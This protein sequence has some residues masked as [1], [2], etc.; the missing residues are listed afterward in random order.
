M[1]E[2]KKIEN[3]GTSCKKDFTSRM[4]ENPWMLSTVVLI[5]LVVIFI[6][7]GLGP[8]GKVI[9]EN[10][11]GEIIVDLAKSQVGDIQIIEVSEKSGIY[12]IDYSSEQGTGV[13]YLTLDGK[14]LIGGLM[15]LEESE[16]DGV[17]EKESYT[18]EDKEKLLSFSE[19]LASKGIK[20]YGAGWCGYCKKLKETFG[21][22]ASPFY[23]ECQN[24]DGSPTE[25][26]NICNEEEIQGFPTIKLNGESS[27]LSALSSLE[28]FA[29]AT[30]CPAPELSN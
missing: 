25:N 22:E 13:V 30:G 14:N 7:Q 2:E 21:G 8:T 10:D 1:E 26:A 18:E 27:G 12:E 23:I 29:E 6:A 4:R 16:N 19:C 9:S 5:A 11:A 28:D 3:D 24:E 17:S 20:A 15:P